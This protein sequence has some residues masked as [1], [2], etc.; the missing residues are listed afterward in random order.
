MTN[1]HTLQN[2]DEM[3]DQASLWIAK[4]DRHLTLDEQQAFKVWLAQNHEHQ[5]L[6]IEMASMWD[7]MDALNRLAEL[8]PEK[9]LTTK[10]PYRFSKLPAMFVAASIILALFIS[11]FNSNY[12][13]NEQYFVRYETAV[14]ENS[15]I[16]LPDNSKV[17]LN[18]N[19]ILL[20]Q[21]NDN[22]RLLELKQ[23]ELLVEVA[24]DKKRPLSVVTNNQVIQA[25]GTIFSVQLSSK[26]LEL[27]VT[28]GKV[29]VG[30][31]DNNKDLSTKT[32]TIVENALAVSKGEI[33][34]LVKTE[35]GYSLNQVAKIDN[36]AI[37]QN[38]SWREGNIVFKGEPLGYVMSEIAR[39]TSVKFEI[40]DEELRNIKIA[41]RFKTGDV[42]GVIN[43]LT[44]NFNIKIDRVNKN[45]VILRKQS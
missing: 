43:A 15:T 41:G 32:L 29:L 28:D 11:F 31:I 10:I 42:N 20:V 2:H 13:H 39:Y 4:I 37:A 38:L 22:N 24:H 3:F 6:I 9:T 40:A 36:K 27:I 14:G 45:L 44:N 1:I 17:L 19:S 23:G 25:V 35:K 34:S 8:F 5:K 21:Y 30:K 18:T 7:K 16:Y 26:A 33:A 12:F